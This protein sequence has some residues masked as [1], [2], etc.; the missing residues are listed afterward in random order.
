LAVT[1]ANG[2]WMV[3]I[4]YEGKRCLFVVNNNAG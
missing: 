2:A 4:D 1:L 3:I